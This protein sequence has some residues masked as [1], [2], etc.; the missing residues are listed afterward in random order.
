MLHKNCRN[1]KLR[2][3]IEP[4]DIPTRDARMKDIVTMILYLSKYEL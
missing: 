1:K 3:V 2:E 4:T